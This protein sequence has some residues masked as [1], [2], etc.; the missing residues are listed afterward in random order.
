MAGGRPTK[1]SEELCNLICQKLISGESLNLICEEPEMPCGSTVYKWLAE[2]AEFSDKYTRARNIQAD[3][4]FEEIV[5]I[6][7][8]GRRDYKEDKDGHE[9][10]D[11]DHIQRSRLRVD[12]RKWVVARMNPR[13]Y[14]EKKGLELS[15]PDGGPVEVKTIE[16]KIID[17]SN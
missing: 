13:K 4:Y 10:P 3:L 11:Y 15:G 1:Y 14:G 2:N 6:S 7:D 8:D 16:R 5:D 12:A 17:P 9:V